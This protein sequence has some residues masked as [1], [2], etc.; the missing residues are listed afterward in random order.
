MKH[1][2]CEVI[3]AWADGAQVQLF[4][5]Y[6]KVWDDCLYNPGFFATSQYRVKPEK[7]EYW[8][9]AYSQNT[10]PEIFFCQGGRKETLVEGTLPMGYSWVGAPVLLW[11]EK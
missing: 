10:N 9:R 11:E 6:T 4:D 2:H 8:S 7:K 3:K 5:E 1:K